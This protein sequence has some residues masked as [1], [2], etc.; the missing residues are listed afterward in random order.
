MSNFVRIKDSAEALLFKEVKFQ[1]RID[2]KQISMHPLISN[3][4]SPEGDPP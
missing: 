1:R 3:K 4:V 2:A